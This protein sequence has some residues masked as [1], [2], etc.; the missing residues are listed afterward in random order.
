MAAS[1]ERSKDPG[2]GA[3]NPAADVIAETA[4]HVILPVATIAPEV[5]TQVRQ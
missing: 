1:S 4:F 3:V 2:G 5:G